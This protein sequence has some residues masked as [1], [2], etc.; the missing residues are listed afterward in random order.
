MHRLGGV[1]RVVVVGDVW[2]KGHD[3]FG[4][5]DEGSHH[6]LVLVLEDVAVVDVTAVRSTELPGDPDQ[7]ASADPDHVLPALLVGV[8][9]QRTS[10]GSGVL[11]P[12][13]AGSKP[14]IS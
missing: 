3:L 1:Q 9:R 11:V 4:H 13:L 8:H 5:H 6:A 2:V 12:P 14:L 7:L 10:A